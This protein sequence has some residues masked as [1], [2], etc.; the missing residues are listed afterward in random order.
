M[1][2]SFLAQGVAHIKGYVDIHENS[3]QDHSHQLPA[4]GRVLVGERILDLGYEVVGNCRV[5]SAARTTND[6]L[7]R[8]CNNGNFEPYV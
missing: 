5:E 3:E 4:T 2:E 8:Q 7:T 6:I 1:V